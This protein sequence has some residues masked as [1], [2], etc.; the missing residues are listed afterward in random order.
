M[1][2]SPPKECYLWK[3]SSIL[4]FKKWLPTRI[5]GSY[6][7]I[8]VSYIF[9]HTQNTEQFIGLLIQFYIESATVILLVNCLLNKTNGCILEYFADTKALYFWKQFLNTFYYDI[10]NVYLYYEK[11]IQAFN[12]S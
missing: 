8:V 9:S 7:Y 2:G 11:E 4:K 10:S 12:Y 1:L 3:P 6:K 5:F